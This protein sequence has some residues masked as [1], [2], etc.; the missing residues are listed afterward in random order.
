MDKNGN[1]LS[2]VPDEELF[3]APPRILTIGYNQPDLEISDPYVPEEVT[4][5]AVDQSARYQYHHDE[6]AKMTYTPT[7][8]FMP[9][10]GPSERIRAPDSPADLLA[11][12]F[13]V[14]YNTQQAID[15]V[16]QFCS[17][18]QCLH[19]TFTP[20]TYEMRFLAYANKAFCLDIT[21]HFYSKKDTPFTI[22][23]VARN[24]GCA[25]YFGD[26]FCQLATQMATGVY[27]WVSVVAQDFPDFTIEEDD[28]EWDWID[29]TNLEIDVLVSLCQRSSAKSIA[30]LREKLAPKLYQ[31]IYDSMEIDAV[32][33]CA[34]VEAI[35]D[36][37]VAPAL[38]DVF[39][40]SS[41]FIQMRCAQTLQ[42]L[43][44]SHEY[45]EL[46]SGA[47]SQR[48]LTTLTA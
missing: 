4:R 35:N 5:C 3:G 17:A 21:I 39:L 46:L 41:E 45:P 32:P 28:D 24:D 20:T 13:T 9:N 11:S 12:H 18:M 14:T 30:S 7:M 19:K 34:L 31:L 26:F 16:L 25:V 40:R 8:G 10:A 42:K 6:F 36:K 2:D 48:V 33:Y 37:E 47:V 43:G 23:E 15:N 38:V 27:G 44:V 29:D 22:V 1:R